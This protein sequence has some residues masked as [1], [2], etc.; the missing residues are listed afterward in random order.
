V[1]FGLDPLQPLDVP[2]KHQRKVWKN[3]Q[4]PRKYMQ[5]IWQKACELPGLSPPGDL[6]RPSA[7]T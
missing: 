1:F 4:N 3:L 6:T 5:E 7:G 2:K